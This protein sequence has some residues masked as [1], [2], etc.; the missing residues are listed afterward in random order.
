MKLYIVRHAIAVPRGTPGIPDDDRA[1]TE[2]GRTKMRVNALGLRA[3][4][5]LPEL[6]LSSPLP[7]ARETAEILLEAFGKGIGLKICPALA[8]S[9]ERP[10]LYREIRQCEKKMPIEMF[11]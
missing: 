4:N 1:L 10:E 3:L 8:P 6:I 9:G 11:L 2:E 5:F 7:R